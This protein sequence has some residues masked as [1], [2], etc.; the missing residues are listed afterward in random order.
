[1]SS[2]Q[3]DSYPGLVLRVFEAMGDGILVTDAAGYIQAVNPAFC[4]ITGYGES[5]IIGKHVRLLKSDRHDDA[6]YASM[7]QS[8]QDNGEWAGEIWYRRKDGSV[9]PE[10]QTVSG[11]RSEDGKVSHYV[12]VFADMSGIHRSRPI[13]EKM[14]WRDALTGLANRALFL[15]Q[16]QQTVAE[17]YREGSFAVVLLLDLDRFKGINEARG[18]P[19]GDALLKQVA[20]SMRKALHSDDLLARLDSDEF[21]VLLPRLIAD[22]E[23]AGRE[24]LVV[25][26]KLRHTLQEN[27]MLNGE[28][29]H[30]ST[31]IGIAIFPEFSEELASDILRRADMAM[32][33]AKAA[34]GG[35]AVFFEAVMGEAIRERYHVERELREAVI[36]SQLRLYVQPQ[37]EA[38]KRQ[39]GAEALVRWEHPER[40]MVLPGMFIPLAETTDLIVS[41]DRWMLA[42]VCRLLGRLKRDGHNLRIAVNVSMRHFQQT[43]FIDEVQRQLSGNGA[44]PNHLMLEITESMVINDFA[45]VVAKM[46]MLRA[47]GVHFSMDDFGTGYSSLAYLKRLPIHELKIDRSFIQDVTTDPNDAALVES[48]LAVAQHLKLQVVAE[49][50]ETKAQ[51]E[52]LNAR[53]NIIQQGYLYGKPEPAEAWLASLSRH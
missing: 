31:S 46:S 5:E 35:R 6:F 14:V 19:T 9:L 38:G 21:A 27:I 44:N 26:E 7:W 12:A 33:R 23:T 36:D 52:F 43:D 48:I 2:P 30:I 53:G 20:R 13:P 32:H 37:L 4:E 29:F 16:L 42:A 39:V 17:A 49:G 40:R 22:R 1:M 8:L 28:R 34:S 24:A 25:A 15:Q 47:L 50:V 3:N 41:V 10:W 18:A 45:D 11:L 51:A